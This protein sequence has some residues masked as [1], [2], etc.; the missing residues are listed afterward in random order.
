MSLKNKM[1]SIIPGTMIALSFL[2]LFQLLPCR[3]ASA[4]SISQTTVIKATLNSRQI[5][6]QNT[7]KTLD[8]APVLVQGRIYI[9][10]KNIADLM[11]IPLNWNANLQLVDMQTAN[12]KIQF[13][14]SKKIVIIDGVNSPFNGIALISN[15]RLMLSLRWL[16]NYTGSQQTFDPN[17]KSI[18]ITFV[19]QSVQSSDVADNSTPVAIF[20]FTKPTYRI[21]ETI[22]YVNLSYD[23]DGDAINLQWT[24][25]QD[26]FFAAGS[27]PVSLQVIDSAGN[28]SAVYTRYIT[29]TN[30]VYMNEVQYNVYNQPVGTSFTIDANMTGNFNNL[31]E[32]PKQISADT[33]RKLLI[34][35]S[36]ES[37]ME[38]GIVYQDTVNGKARLYAN[39]TNGTTN[40][41]RFT[42]AVTNPT[43]VPI[44]LITTNKGEVYP[45]VFANLIG[46]VASTNFLLHDPSNIPPIIVPA[47]ATLIY[48]QPADLY[49][50]QGINLIY[51]V[52]SDGPLQYTFVASDADT[53]LL[54]PLNFY[55]PLA[56][57]KNIR[58]TFPV[59]QKT[60]NIDLTNLA[61]PMELTIGD[62][63]NDV[64]DIGYDPLRGVQTTNYGNYGIV[65]TIH[66]TNP[67][68]MAVLML[69]KGGYFK[70]PF[71]INNTISLA[72]SSGIITAYKS[73]QVLARTT[74]SENN[75][76]LEFTPPAGSSFPIDI[77]FYP[78]HNLN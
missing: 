50:G 20:A 55:K 69:A 77:I 37:I 29:I 57:N 27:Y 76:D 13:V 48:M 64:F 6:V 61:A 39:H 1:K 67:G 23:P 70:G 3:I 33:S 16:S 2:F 8:A 7:S 35:D 24:G 11:N 32:L 51:D 78:L 18:L 47:G 41:M 73:I 68:K 42:I 46:S 15:G 66:A 38:S 34:S 45:S 28:Q 19:T 52:E 54:L 53:S 75:F 4:A 74:G 5:I 63:I 58:G 36:P 72:P 26:V 17:T 65:Y 12:S 43:N 22:G 25:R 30:V 10:A 60:W 40:K 44:T 59:S 31:P 71:V 62:G 49:P 56:Y 21:G 9:P 14:P